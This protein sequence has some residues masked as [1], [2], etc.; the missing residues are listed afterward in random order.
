[1]SMSR[2]MLELARENFEDTKM[3]DLI[4]RLFQEAGLQQK[5]NISFDDFQKILRDYREDLNLIS[6]EM[7]CTYTHG[8][9]YELVR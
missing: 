9:S 1:M 3:N 6:L 7:N 4:N 8:V 5:D 2:S